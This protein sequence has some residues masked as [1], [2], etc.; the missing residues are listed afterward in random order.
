MK[1]TPLKFLIG[2]AILLIFSCNTYQQVPYFQDLNRTSVIQEEIRN[3]TP[4]TIQKGDILGIS[5][6]SLNPEASAEFNYNLNRVN[7]VNTDYSPSNAVTGYLVDDKG[8]VDLPFLGTMKVE[9]YTTNDLHDQLV[10]SLSN[11]LKQPIVNIRIL[12]FKVSVL[13]DVAKPA[14]YSFPTE[15]VTLSDALGMAGDLNITAKRQT[16]L[17]IREVDGKRTF[18]PIDLTSKKIFESPYY[19]LKNNDV[20]YVD[21]DRTKYA[22]VD[23]GYRTA[24]IVISA[25]SVVAIVMTYYLYHK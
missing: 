23:R 19:Y 14:V 24:T 21:P 1:H 10:K 2:V 11:Y 25:L 13:G 3:Y 6:T 20:I 4:L 5:V 9:G 22:P 7:G 15:K 16:V 8:N 12:N 18:I 17:L